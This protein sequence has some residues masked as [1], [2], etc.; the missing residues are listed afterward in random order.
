[1]VLSVSMA[2]VLLA[3]AQLTGKATAGPAPSP[4]PSPKPTPAAARPAAPRPAATAKTTFDTVKG[5]KLP[6]G[7][8]VEFPAVLLPATAVQTTSAGKVRYFV[9]AVKKDSE[10]MRGLA[11][12]AEKLRGPILEKAQQLPDLVGSDDKYRALFKEVDGA[13]TAALG[14]EKLSR[15]ADVSPDEAIVVEVSGMEA[16]KDVYTWES[17]KDKPLFTISPPPP[18]TA[19][20][21]RLG[22]LRLPFPEVSTRQALVNMVQGRPPDLAKSLPEF[23]DRPTLNGD[24][25]LESFNVAVEMYNTELKRRRVYSAQRTAEDVRLLL[26]RFDRVLGYEEL[27]VTA[28]VTPRVDIAA[29]TYTR[30]HGRAPGVFVRERGRPPATFTS[31]Y[32]ANTDLMVCSYPP[33]A[34]VK[35]DGREV[36]TTP[37]VARGMVGAKLPVALTL[38]GHRPLEVTETVAAHASGVKRLD[39]GLDV[40]QA[41]PARLMSD[42]E[43]K[44]VFTAEFK[45]TRPFTVHVSTPGEKPAEKGKKPKVDK[46]D[47]KFVEWVEEFRGLLAVRAAWFQ[48]APTADEA[49]VAFQLVPNAPGQSPEAILKTRLSSG[50]ETTT[51]EAPLSFSSDKDSASRVL[52]RLAERLKSCCWTQMVQAAAAP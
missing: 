51:T 12:E 25:E 48:A 45:P 52:M 43:A 13:L 28:T 10:Y 39:Y 16:L 35:V 30:I 14:T 3:A 22:D 19:F 42:D 7:R 2:G 46:K 9:L 11:A 33:G 49:D 18:L 4:S 41:P 34:T 27:P 23:P 5:G 37:Y 21:D 32:F 44:R 20:P 36:G 17:V 26:A 38:A 24:R 8:A 1:M 31:R 29:E 6:A 40:E 15:T 47:K 50:D